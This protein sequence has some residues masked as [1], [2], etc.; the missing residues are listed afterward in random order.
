MTTT[1]SSRSLMGVILMGL[2]GGGLLS[3]EKVPKVAE[4]ASLVD[5]DDLA[6]FEIVD[7]DRNNFTLCQLAP[8]RYQ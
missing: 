6:Q 1:N 7:L 8:K 3:E 2:L 4:F 5:G